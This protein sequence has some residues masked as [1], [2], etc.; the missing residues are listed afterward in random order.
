MPEPSFC[1]CGIKKVTMIGTEFLKGQGL[2]NRLFCYVSARC[3]AAD[4]NTTF[5]TF[6]GEYL[7]ADFL[8][9]DLGKK[10]TPEEAAAMH[11]YQEAEK[12]IYV[13]NSPHD[14][15]H[16]CYVAGAD[17]EL[18]QV[19]EDT[20]LYGNLQDESY[21]EKHR[22]EIR[23]W[24]QVKP[25]AD[26]A[27]YTA[28]DLCI[29]NIRGGEY[30]EDPA[31]FL[32]KKY[33]KDAMAWMRR[34]NPAMRFMIVTDD[35]T[36]ANR[37]L[38]GIPAYHFDPAG[39]Y[40]TVKNARY[41]IVSNS[42]FAFFPAYTSTTLRKAIAPMY[43]A[44]HNVSD[45]YWASEQ[46]IYSIFTYMDRDGKTYS[47]EQCREKLARYTWPQTRT[48]PWE[49]QDPEVLA[50]ARKQHYQ[51]LCLKALR[52]AGRMCTGKG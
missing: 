36:A 2:G 40:V 3:L 35:V 32:R 1:L 7:Q 28:D 14:M 19:P 30:A 44:R 9:I 10:L 33:W 25:A 45:G 6:G 34:E 41:L 31:L 24:L 4:R 39:D 38:P 52:K 27:A 46:N 15:I 47:A 51:Q 29:L 17:P 20:L 23:Q 48:Q 12:R 42:S 50:L 8:E 13:K 18:W 16:G 22:E 37:L 43:W 5:A 49:A 21:F 11:R 26:F